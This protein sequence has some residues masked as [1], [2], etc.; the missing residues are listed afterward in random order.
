[1]QKSELKTLAIPYILIISVVCPFFLTFISQSAIYSFPK[2]CSY[3]VLTKSSCVLCGMTRAMSEVTHGDF[4]KATQYNFLWPFV[5][6]SSLF[7]II[8]SIRDIVFNKNT[9]SFYL[10]WLKRNLFFI[11]IIF[12]IL[13]LTKSFLNILI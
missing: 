13:S 1:V 2:V 4:S 7:I 6:C 11:V 8:T 12:I 9:C 5:V 3:K 10:N